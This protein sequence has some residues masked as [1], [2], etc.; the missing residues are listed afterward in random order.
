M[1]RKRKEEEEQKR[2][3]EE[4]RKIKE[5]LLKHKNNMQPLRSNSKELRE[6]VKMHFDKQ[7]Q[8]TNCKGQ[9]TYCQ[10]KGYNGDLNCPA[11]NHVIS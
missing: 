9:K 7:R 4:E 6:Y 3:E 2:K 10:P 5:P 8:L 11:N 1:L